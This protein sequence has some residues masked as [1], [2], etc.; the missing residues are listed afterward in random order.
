VNGAV[1]PARPAA[2]MLGMVKSSSQPQAVAAGRPSAWHRLAG[3]WLL[4]A[5]VALAAGLVLGFLLGL[6]TPSA[7]SGQPLAPEAVP[8]TGGLAAPGTAAPTAADAPRQRSGR[9]Q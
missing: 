3:G 6:I 5:A 4:P 9:H 1:K 8:A 2:E 7:P